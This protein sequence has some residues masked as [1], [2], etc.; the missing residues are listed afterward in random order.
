MAR[1]QGDRVGSAGEVDTRCGSFLHACSLL[2]RVDLL[3][4]GSLQLID[5]HAHLLLQFGRQRE[6]LAVPCYCVSQLGNMLAIGFLLVERPRECHGLPLR[7]IKFNAAGLRILT[8]LN[9]PSSIKIKPFA[10][11]RLGGEQYNNQ[12]Y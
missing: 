9:F 7:V 8:H 3:L 1:A 10:G 12:N 5:A 4:C 11:P 6:M 2:Q